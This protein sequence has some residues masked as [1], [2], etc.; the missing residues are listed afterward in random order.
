MMGLGIED[1]QLT[2]RYIICDLAI[3]TIERDLKHIQN[4]KLNKAFQNTLEIL[5]K[6]LFNERKQINHEMKVAHLKYFKTEKKDEY[7]TNF[8][9]TKYNADT[10]ITFANMALYHKINDKVEGMIKQKS[11]SDE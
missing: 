11:H 3:R 6:D 2:Y 9:F 1:T 7:F 8:Y 10:E 5:L 4:L